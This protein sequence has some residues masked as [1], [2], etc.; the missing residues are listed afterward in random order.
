M[1]EAN[2]LC[3]VD[4]F[5]SRDLYVAGGCSGPSA[6]TA[7]HLTMPLHA[8]A[9]PP[10]LATKR[11]FCFPILCFAGG[12]ASVA[13]FAF[14]VVGLLMCYCW[15]LTRNVQPTQPTPPW[16]ENLPALT[17]FDCAAS[18][19]YAAQR[20]EAV[21]STSVARRSSLPDTGIN[22]S[23]LSPLAA[24]S[25]GRR[26]SLAATGINLAP[27]S[28]LKLSA[29]PTTVAPPSGLAPPTGELDAEAGGIASGM[30]DHL[31]QQ[32]IPFVPQL[33]TVISYTL[34]PPSPSTGWQPPAPSTT[35]S[36]ASQRQP[37]SASS[38]ET[39]TSPSPSA[40]ASVAPKRRGCLT[41]STGVSLSPPP[42]PVAA[43]P[44]MRNSLPPSNSRREGLLKLSLETRPEAFD[45]DSH[46][47]FEDEEDDLSYDLDDASCWGDFAPV[48]PAL[49]PRV[50]T[51]VTAR[52]GGRISHGVGQM[53]SHIGRASRAEHSS[54]VDHSSQSCYQPGR[55]RATSVAE[56]D[57]Q[58]VWV[59]RPVE[60]AFAEFSKALCNSLVAHGLRAETESQ[61]PRQAS[62]QLV[63]CGVCVFLL[64]PA[65][66]S[67]R[68]SVGH[69]RAAC[70][71]G[72]AVAIVVLPSSRFAGPG[73]KW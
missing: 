11:T 62:Q 44:E 54:Q 28:P 49:M 16:E 67:S 27:P 53:W 34:E 3:E 22:L 63:G 58:R 10:L 4:R 56:S 15:W 32:R 1:K 5:G 6:T 8:C 23:P 47:F 59:H 71:V 64:S 20:G 35:C 39:V 48:K 50:S 36:D 45:S 9:S 18:A 38:S 37:P 12:C 42:P 19:A 69:M 31:R 46:S 40:L 21:G 33:E 65:F 29:P 7:T 60:P 70:A 13:L 55:S 43:V 41:P 30:G 26:S 72:K 57:P 61:R 51:R 2:G 14:A 17:S 24:S 66:F 73:Q 52:W 68:R 25:S